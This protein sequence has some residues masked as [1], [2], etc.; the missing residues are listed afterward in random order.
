MQNSKPRIV[1]LTSAHLRFDTRIFI[2]I[3]S[4]LANNGFDVSLVVAD[5]YGNENKN[6][7]SI[8]DVGPKTGGR[9][10]RFTKT[11]NLVFKKAIELNADIY[12]LHDPELIFIGLKLKKLGKKVIFDSH[13]D[14]PKQ[15]LSK[16]Y[17]NKIIAILL[18]K[19]FTY[20]ER[21]A[22]KKFDAVV[23]V[24]Q[25]I[26]DKF[27]KINSNTVVIN[28]FPL[29]DELVNSNNWNSK[30]SEIAYVGAIEKIRGIEQVLEALDYS[31]NVKLN[32]AGMF[33]DK[34]FEE[35]IKN[36]H[37]S[38]KVNFFNQ[39]DRKGVTN[40]L[41]KSQAGIV[42]L[43]PVPN[44]VNAQ[45]TKMFEYMSA[46]LPVIA[47]DFPLWRE[48]IERNQCGICVNP[49]D[50]EAIGKAFQYIINNPAAAE[51][52]GKNG[53]RAIEERYNWSIEEVK[54]IALY[55]SLLKA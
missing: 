24:T 53:R 17:L 42:T 35:K 47:S 43:L 26:G 21:W 19:S 8:Y 48:V 14:F 18:S 9:I 13:E 50:P 11:V 5:G 31:N 41:A 20:F 49:L 27:S 46:G 44:Y 22:C 36:N 4:S 51:K 25:Q 45:P 34:S 54:L 3:C 28:N 12:H 37:L 39:L 32:L 7:V 55:K 2:K 38:T 16:H 23:T 15:L 29:L 40:L 33:S 10:S 52:M 6:N 1:H 30:K